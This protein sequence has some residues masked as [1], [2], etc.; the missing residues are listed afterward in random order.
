MKQQKGFTLIELIVVIVILG[1]LAATALPKFFD[2]KSDA[3]SAAVQGV[4]G[5]ISSG[6]SINYAVRSLHAGSGVAVADCSAGSSLIEGGL[7]ANY[8]IAASGVAAGVT[9][10]GC[11]LTG[12]ANDGSKTATFTVTGIN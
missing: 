7:P 5:G 9:T 4:A 3:A 8:S 2:L 11:V 6:N 10:S 1:I 12:P